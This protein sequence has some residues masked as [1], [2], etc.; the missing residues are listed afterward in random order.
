MIELKN[1]FELSK[2]EE[3]AK[4]HP[5]KIDKPFNQKQDLLNTMVDKF[6]EKGVSF[7]QSECALRQ[8]YRF[9]VPASLRSH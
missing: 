6:E 8:K 4:V 2:K 3:V 7:S 5:K 1:V 9:S